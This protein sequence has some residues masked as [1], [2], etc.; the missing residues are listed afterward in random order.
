MSHPSMFYCESAPS[1]AISHLVLS[2]WEFAAQGENSAPI[3]HEVFPDG[4]I[5]I[6]YK[7]NKSFGIDGLFVHGLSLETF[8]TEVFAGDAFWGMR[9]MPSACSNV[10]RSDPALVQ[11]GE[12]I[13][14]KNFTHLTEGLLKKLVACENFGEA[15]EIYESRMKSLELKPDAADE[16]VAQAVKVIEENRGEVKISALAEAVNL[17]VR[18]LERRFRKS[19][20]LSP[21]QYA[22]A[23][24]IRATAIS[25]VVEAEMNWANRA[26]E[27]GFTDQ[28]HLTHEFSTLTGRSPNSFAKQ[29]KRIEHGDFLK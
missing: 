18:Q 9:L 29:V 28:A 1:P 19:S 16:K 26:A 12:L 25:L 14:S 11:S 2:F 27:M 5:S 21:K 3:V 6:I 15:V 13:E 10:L 23:R 4:C 20:G 24:R 22:R 17:S 8:K 7:R